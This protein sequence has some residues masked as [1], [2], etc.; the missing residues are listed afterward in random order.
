MLREPRTEQRIGC[1]G[2]V[3]AVAGRRRPAVV[4]GGRDQHVRAHADAEL[5]DVDR[6]ARDLGFVARG[7]RAGREL[8]DQAIERALAR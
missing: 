1:G 8:A 5:D 4:L 6:E 7:P 3:E 2:V